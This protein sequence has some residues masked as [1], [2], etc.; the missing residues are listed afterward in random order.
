MSQ[1]RN[2]GLALTPGFLRHPAH[3]PMQQLTHGP[4]SITLILLLDARSSLSSLSGTSSILRVGLL[5][6]APALL[7]K[8]RDQIKRSQ[9]TC[10]LCSYHASLTSPTPVLPPMT[11]PQWPLRAGLPSLPSHQWPPLPHTHQPC[12]CPSDAAQPSPCLGCSPTAPWLP[13]CLRGLLSYQ[14]PHSRLPNVRR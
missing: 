10:P 9:S 3:Q 14:R 6:S 1:V 8:Q 12:A 5:A 2:Q 4:Q 7:R 11:S 13:S